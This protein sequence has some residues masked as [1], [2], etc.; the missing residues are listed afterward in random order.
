VNVGSLAAIRPLANLTVY[1]MSKAALEAL[2]KCAALELAPRGIRVNAVNPATVVTDIHRRAGMQGE[3]YDRYLIDN[4][5]MH[6]LGR[7]GQPSDCSALISYIASDACA[8][9]T[10]Q[11]IGLDG[12]R[13]LCVPA[14][15]DLT[16]PTTSSI[17]K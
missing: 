13:S 8:W 11:C 14:A 7:P 15:K 3:A 4:N 16:D 12:G 17:V 1:S 5:V 9:M 2:T 10:G 6:P